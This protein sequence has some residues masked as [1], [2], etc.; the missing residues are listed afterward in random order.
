M[1]VQRK[2]KCLCD[3]A[4]SDGKRKN[5]LYQ[6]P[7]ALTFEMVEPIGFGLQHA[8]ILAFSLLDCNLPGVEQDASHL[9]TKV[10]TQTLG[11]R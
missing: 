11:Q 4:T 7:A 1:L 3:L 5:L 9:G 2:S 6:I 10:R 8:H